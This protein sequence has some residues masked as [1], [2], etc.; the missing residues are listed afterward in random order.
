[1]SETIPN[2]QTRITLRDIAASCGV[3]HSTVSRALKNS[4]LIS[5]S[6]RTRIQE[7]AKR[8]GYTPDPMVSALAN[9][10]TRMRDRVQTSR[11]AIVI[12]EHLLH[13]WADLIESAQQKANQLGFSM[14]L[15]VWDA[16]IPHKRHSEILHSRGIRGLV[17]GPVTKHNNLERIEL[18]WDRFSVV[19][20]GNFMESQQFN[21][22]APNHFD[23]MQLCLEKLKQRGAKR[24]AFVTLDRIN[25][26]TR[27][28]LLVAYYGQHMVTYPGQCA[29][30]SHLIPYPFQPSDLTELK[31]WYE[32][33]Q[34]DA[35]VSHRFILDLAGEADIEFPQNFQFIGIDLLERPK[36][37]ETVSG[38][39][40]PNVEIGEQ[41]VQLLA[42][43]IAV[44]NS[45]KSLYP[46]SVYIDPGWRDVETN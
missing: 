37:P 25:L 13:T 34:P 8:L 27:S 39:V 42:N 15:Y 12:G 20:L 38:V 7:T 11:L 35:W 36:T 26:R 24:P 21:C 14:E 3:N 17:M 30:L 44:G 2:S 41:C 40:H 32:K 28:Q 46:K 23:T 31:R 19:T 29:P 1:M 16:S 5:E 45:G 43:E 4:P 18:D 6:T 22:V 9:Y 33:Q 10:R